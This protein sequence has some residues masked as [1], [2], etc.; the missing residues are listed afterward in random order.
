MTELPRRFR[1][2]PNLVEFGRNAYIALDAPADL[3]GLA[4]DAVFNRPS[5]DGR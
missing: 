4:Y 3:P 5:G 1:K 2:L